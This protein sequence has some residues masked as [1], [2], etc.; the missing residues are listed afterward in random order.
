L[1]LFRFVPA[2]GFDVFEADLDFA[3]EFPP[4]AAVL[5]VVVAV[6]G[7]FL[8]PAAFVPFFPGPDAGGPKSI[9]K[10]VFMP[11]RTLLLTSS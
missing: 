7:L 10:V 8:A 2:L 6:A 11:S 5:K 9:F 1:I 3:P 4:L